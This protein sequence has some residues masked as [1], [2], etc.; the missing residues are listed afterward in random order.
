MP[1]PAEQNFPSGDVE[2]VTPG[3]T[4]S[5]TDYRDKESNINSNW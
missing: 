4:E 5:R 3:H 2:V 1:D